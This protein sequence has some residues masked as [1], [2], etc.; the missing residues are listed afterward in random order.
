MNEHQR[1]RHSTGEDAV[2][3][4]IAA[5]DSAACAGI[6]ADIRTC[7]ALRTRATTVMTA[8]TAQNSLR[9]EAIAPVTPEMLRLQ[10]ECAVEQIKPHAVKIGL[11]PSAEIIRT[12][13]E[14][15][16]R[17]GLTDNV[18]VDTVAAPT[19][20]GDFLNEAAMELWRQ[21]MVNILLPISRIAT[22]NLPELTL[23]SEGAPAVD[24]LSSC[25]CPNILVKG[26][27]GSDIDCT[28]DMLWR[29]DKHNPLTFTAQRRNTRH[30]R[31]T[32]C[33]LSTAIACYLA[34]EYPVEEAVK[35]A[36]DFLQE[37]IRIASR[38]LAINNE[39]VI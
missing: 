29:K 28:R 12:V 25:G 34:A 14:E 21:E 7:Q 31:G 37:R 30:L 39:S 32:G 13:A 4:I 10:M 19:A 27:H 5:S 36:H 15:L 3:M 11:L 33:V 24:F 38:C 1:K 26:G 22:P 8:V 17:L 2:I 9:M 23:L 16:C 35:K 18:V 20:N 6:Q